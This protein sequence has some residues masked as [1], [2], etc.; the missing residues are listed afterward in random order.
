MVYLQLF[1]T[2]VWCVLAV[3]GFC[4]MFIGAPTPFVAAQFI[5]GYVFIMLLALYTVGLFAGMISNGDPRLIAACVACAA[6][7]PLGF[8]LMFA[9]A[10]PI[11]ASGQFI[12]GFVFIMILAVITAV[13]VLW[14]CSYVCET[15]GC[16]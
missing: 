4:L 9:G 8:T 11:F 2:L 12:A 14:G 5:V 10:P 16:C 3:L 6:L 15:E 7:I 13:L 1:L